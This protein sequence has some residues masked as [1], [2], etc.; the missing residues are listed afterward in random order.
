MPTTVISVRGQDR[1]ALLTDPL[2]VY[3]GRKCAGWPASVWGNP[4][5][6]EQ[7][8]GGTAQCVAHYELTMRASVR[9]LH[10]TDDE[11]D[12]VGDEL[13]SITN[14]LGVDEMNRLYQATRRLPELRGKVLGC[15]CGSWQPGEPDILCHAV[16]L[17]KMADA[18][19][20]S[21]H[22]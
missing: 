14:G 2:F 9:F 10:A 12:A 19:E 3:V 5:H 20:E 4:W 11:I 21:T 7:F 17:A 8:R 1:A 15:W 22:G 18:L 16:V 13:W 6:P